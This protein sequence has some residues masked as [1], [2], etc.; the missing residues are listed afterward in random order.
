RRDQDVRRHAERRERLGLHELVT[1]QAAQGREARA[2]GEQERLAAGEQENVAI[3]RAHG[4]SRRAAR[5][6]S[7]HAPYHK[8]MIPAEADAVLDFWFA[9]PAAR[10]DA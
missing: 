4:K 6:A 2:V 10:G 1:H 8:P 7:A 3:R 9:P 5:W